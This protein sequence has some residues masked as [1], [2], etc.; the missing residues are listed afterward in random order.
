MNKILIALMVTVIAVTI[1]QVLI[2]YWVMPGIDSRN[3]EAI[4][5]IHYVQQHPE[6]FQIIGI[7]SVCERHFVAIFSYRYCASRIVPEDEN[8]VFRFLVTVNYPR[9]YTSPARWLVSFPITA[10]AKALAYI[11]DFG[12]AHYST[13]GIYEE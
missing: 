6:E 13:G 2:R 7:G 1:E 9:A 11:D 12:V 8:A 10:N 4:D 5:F 3:A